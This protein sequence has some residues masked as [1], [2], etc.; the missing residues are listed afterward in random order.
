MAVTSI[1]A[2]SDRVDKVITYVKNPDKTTEKP[3][4]FPEAVTARSAVGDVI[5]YATN[6]DKTEQMMYVTGI[7]CSPD[8]AIDDFMRTKLMWGK[9][10]G[11][12]AY[13]GYQSFKEGEGEITAETVHNI[14]VKMAEELWGDRFEV[15]VAT[16]LNTGHYHNHFVLNSVSI[17]DGYKYHRTMNDYRQMKSV[18]D[19]LCREAGLQIIEEPSVARGKN[20]SEWAAEKLGRPTVRGRIR[21]NIDYAILMSRTEKEFI[22]TMKELGY[23]FK[24][25]KPDGTEYVHPGIKPPGAKSFFRFSGLGE[26]YDLDSIKRRII[27]NSTVPGTPFLI[28]KRPYRNWEPPKEDDLKGLP[29]MYRKYC[30]RLY[31]YVCKPA[32]KEYIPMALREDI[33]KLDDYIEQMDFLYG[34]RI[35]NKESLQV[36]KLEFQNE[37]F[38]LYDEK[39]RL[40]SY[41]K[42]AERNNKGGL[43]G[44]IHLDIKEVS[45]KIRELKKKIDLCDEVSISSDEV[46]KR[47]N[48]PDKKPEIPILKDGKKKLLP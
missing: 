8:T 38:I 25:Y 26:N 46:L 12:L 27:E 23:E 39:K 10:G 45:R 17:T 33:A 36:K 24:F 41:K 3:E 31:A 32:R 2:I 6:V 15:V 43:I 22:K 28:E 20:Y 1:W 18:S 4:L 5:D 47:L 13:H 48:A 19:R 35:E 30:I 37:L 40:Y 9:T 11:R 42:W 29:H 44:K 21:E 7:N 14:G 16:H 34:N